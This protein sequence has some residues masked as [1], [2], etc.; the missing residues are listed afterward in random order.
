[1]ARGCGCGNANRTRWPTNSTS[2]LRSATPAFAGA[3]SAA[4][5]QQV[6]QDRAPPLLFH[7]PKLACQATRQLSGHPRIKSGDRADFGHHHQNRPHRALRTRPRPIS[8]R[9]CRLRRRD[10]RHQHQTR[11]V[12]RRVELHHL[13]EYLSSKLLV[14]FL[15]SPSRMR[16]KAEIVAKILGTL[17]AA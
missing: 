4:R 13:T 10:G 16:E 5:H 15:T 3:G 17:W 7:Q 14:Y 9:D 12:P 1:M 8:R 2:T 6:E 11:R